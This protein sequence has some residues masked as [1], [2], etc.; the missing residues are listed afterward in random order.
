M[1][2]NSRE[3]IIKKTFICFKLV[4]NDEE[5]SLV[6]TSDGVSFQEKQ[7]N[8]VQAEQICSRVLNKGFC[9]SSVS[10][11]GVVKQNMFSKG[12]RG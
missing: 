8:R 5:N 6:E 2:E 1:P 7:L 9:G 11:T 10:M 12:G 3:E 4:E